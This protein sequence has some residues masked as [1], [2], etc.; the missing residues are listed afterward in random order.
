MSADRE[1][2][3]A[4]QFGILR[5]E[6][7]PGIK[8]AAR[9]EKQYIRQSEGWEKL[10]FAKNTPENRNRERKRKRA[11]ARPSPL[12]R[13]RSYAKSRGELPSPESSILVWG[14]KNNK[15]GAEWTF[16]APH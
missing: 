12:W 16:V 6:E 13:Q 11:A 7:R 10:E 2:K 8:D 15:K 4:K 14:T 5:W 9:S 3:Q 1:E